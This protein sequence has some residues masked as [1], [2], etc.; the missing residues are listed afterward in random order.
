MAEDLY[1]VL[2][3]QQG[4]NDR[5]LK[6]A[7]RE[8][9]RKYHPDINK[10]S[11]AADRFKEVQRAYDVLSDPQKRAQYD[12]F[13]VVDDQAGGSGSGFPGGGFSGA[14]FSGI[15]DIF[16]AFFFLSDSKYY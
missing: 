15:D 8:L 9:A 13:G 1:A 3:V 7:Y 5:E 14:G 6:R 2:G 16:D 12:Q 4:S 10:E 11:G